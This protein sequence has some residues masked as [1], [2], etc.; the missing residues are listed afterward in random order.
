MKKLLLL[1]ALVISSTAFAKTQIHNYA[2]IVSSINNGIPL[3]VVT[4]FAQCSATNKLAITAAMSAAYFS[5]K[6]IGVTDSYVATSLIHFTMNDPFFPGQPVN[7]YVRYTITPDKT[8]KVIL[9]VLDA[10]NYTKL[11]DPITF[12]CQLDVSTKIFV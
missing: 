3:H 5:P 4:N 1:G 6:E 9:N 2:D 10:A 8:V 11:I 7:E 12:T